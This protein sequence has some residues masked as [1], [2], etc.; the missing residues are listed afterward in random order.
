MKK[1]CFLVMFF[2]ACAV[3]NIA[4]AGPNE[5]YQKLV[6]NEVKWL[7]EDKA[8]WP[9]PGL[10]DEEI[11]ELIKV[12]Q[13]AYKKAGIEMTPLQAAVSLGINSTREAVRQS[14]MRSAQKAQG[15]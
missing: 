5:S 15:K 13:D 9:I 1:F 12:I 3:C 6:N 11:Q 14:F 8:S 4:M 10:N 2:A 7:N